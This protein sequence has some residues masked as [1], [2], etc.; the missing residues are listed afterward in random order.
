MAS[1]PIVRLLSFLL[2]L[3]LTVGAIVGLSTVSRYV[4]QELPTQM[5]TATDEVKE[6][7]LSAVIPEKNEFNFLALIAFVLIVIGTVFMIL[8]YYKVKQKN[9]ARAEIEG[10]KYNPRDEVFFK[11]VAYGD[12]SKVKSKRASRINRKR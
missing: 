7:K 5:V 12:S 3:V 6:T 10:Q 1:K 2:I 4:S 8:T 11:S 9:P